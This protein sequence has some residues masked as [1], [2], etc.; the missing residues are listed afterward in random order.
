MKHIILLGD[1][2][3]DNGVYVN[4]GKDTIAN[5][6]DQ[7]PED[8]TA[9]LLAVDGTV[10]DGVTK[11]LPRVPADATHLFVSV[12]G[13]DALGEI[14]ILQMRASS[15]AE[16][17]SEV[18]SVAARFEDRYKR[19]LDSVL[20]L[21]L[22]TAVCTIYYPRYPDA[23]LQRMAVAALA[24]FNDVIIRLA[25]VAGLP[26][27]D[28]RYVCDEDT[29]YANPI[30]PSVAGGAKIA[31]TI[32][33][34]ASEHDY[35]ANKTSVYVGFGAVRRNLGR[36]SDPLARSNRGE[37]EGTTTVR[38][39]ETAG[40]AV[41][42]MT[43][44]DVAAVGGWYGE[45]VSAVKRERENRRLGITEPDNFL[46]GLLEK[47]LSGLPSTGVFVEFDLEEFA[48]DAR[49][50]AEDID[51][52]RN[53]DLLTLRKLLSYYRHK[54]GSPFSRSFDSTCWEELA[55]NGQLLSILR[56]YQHIYRD[57]LDRTTVSDLAKPAR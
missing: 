9:T 54:S 29:D 8:W 49:A 38:F 5:L 22:P 1:S 2:I 21:K 15:S 13:N 44:S 52:L 25:S 31:S 37:Q 35:V 47:M 42:A 3:F 39:T 23:R 17:F 40:S 27:I 46:S 56:R 12:G 16:V 41:T 11:Q 36:T 30:E 18:S 50:Y 26:L 24:S 10:T 4:G 53:A 33:R 32:V 51:E 43:L 57:T 28:L 6:R 55:M 34:V 19:M 48:K 7:M 45:V 20:K 14:G